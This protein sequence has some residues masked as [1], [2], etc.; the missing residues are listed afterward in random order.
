MHFFVLYLSYKSKAMSKVTELKKH[1]K[2]GD[3]YRRSDLTQWSNAVDR[4]V[5]SLVKDGTLQKL[6]AGLYYY[7]NESVFGNT[8]PDEETLVR[9]FLKD[10]YFLV[11]S[12]NDYN[13]LGVGTT[14]LYNKRVVYNHKRHGEFKLGGKTFTFVAK[15]RF[16][17]K[18][19]PEFLLVDLVNN[20][21][22][23]AED[24]EFVLKNVSVKVKT[25]DLKKLKRTVKV[26]GN[27]RA[28][29]FLTPLIRQ[30][31]VKYVH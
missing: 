19:T 22:N 1:L 14:Q 25:M 24:S 2:R 23:L 4:H 18:V 21:D 9:S 8:P 7:P 13:T 10:D 27:A 15:H 28:K 11:T 6:T 17:K 31:E 26:Y 20:L 16:P 12:P 30:S 5:G 3:V 29:L